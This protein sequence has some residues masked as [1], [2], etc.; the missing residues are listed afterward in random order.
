LIKFGIK[1]MVVLDEELYENMKRRSRTEEQ[2][3]NPT[4]NTPTAKSTNWFINCMD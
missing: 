2:Q 4:S 1:L 3:L